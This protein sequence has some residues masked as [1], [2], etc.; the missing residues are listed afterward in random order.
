MI[1]P[2]FLLLTT[3]PGLP[4]VVCAATPQTAAR[5]GSATALW[6]WTLTF[7]TCPAKGPAVLK[8][9][10]APGPHMNKQISS[11]WQLQMDQCHRSW[12]RPESFLE[13][14]LWQR[15]V[16]IY[17]VCMDWFWTCTSN[18]R[19]GRGGRGVCLVWTYAWTPRGHLSVGQ[20]RRRR[21]TTVKICTNTLGNPAL[22]VLSVE[23]IIEIWIVECSPSHWHLVHPFVSWYNLAPLILCF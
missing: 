18:G 4:Y 16:E 14:L 12:S 20:W 8:A 6:A 15:H 7:D 1:W 10:A 11:C 23:L 2:S 22:Y 5:H 17:S 19:G 13:W 3:S 9:S 21:H